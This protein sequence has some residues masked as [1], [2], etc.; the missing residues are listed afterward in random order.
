MGEY[1]NKKNIKS[2]MKKAQ[3]F[4]IDVFIAIAIIAIGL[5]VLY[6]SKV[7]P[8]SPSQTAALS[9][10]LMN[11]FNSLKVYQ[12]DNIYVIQLIKNGN[13]TNL[14]NT[15]LQQITQYYLYGMND[16]AGNITRNVTVDALPLQ[17]AFSLHINGTLIYQSRA[18]D[19]R[20]PN[21]ITTKR[22][23]TGVTNSSYYWGPYIA[24]VRV[25][26]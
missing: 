13:I 18:N 23:V 10:D 21:L 8:P 9:A 12:V 5:F 4:S 14:D 17:Y 7:T 25:W 3:F 22:L 2:W 1:K 26:R 19:S 15:L 24:E 16:I 11:S 6:T 20:T